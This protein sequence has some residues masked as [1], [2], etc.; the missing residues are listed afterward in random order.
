DVPFAL[1]TSIVIVTV[2]LTLAQIVTLGTLPELASSRTPLADSA[3]RF[4][5][6][7]GAAMITIGAVFSTAGNNMGGALSGSRTL[8]ALAEQGDLPHFFGRIH[9][10]FRTPVNAILVTAGISLVLALSGTFQS[11]AQASAISRLLV[12]V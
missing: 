3:A 12:Y 11:M 5:G 6:A 1:I 8:F 10:V 2:L 9:P 4:L 7:A